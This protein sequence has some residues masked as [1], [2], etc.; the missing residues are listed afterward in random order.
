MFAPS[1]FPTGP[2]ETHLMPSRRNRPALSFRPA[3]LRLEE[4]AVPSASIV[5]DI[6]TDRAGFRL[7][8]L[9]AVGNRVFFIT[10]ST[11]PLANVTLWQSDGTAAGTTPVRSGQTT[12]YDLTPFNGK[13]Y[14]FDNE[15]LWVT[16]GTAAGTTS[17]KGFTGL[18]PSVLGVLNGTLY[19]GADGGNTG[20]ELWKTDGTATGTA[21]VKDINPGTGYGVF[22]QKGVVANNLLYFMGTDG[23][24]GEELW[25]TDGTAAG[26]QMVKDL[27]PGSGGVAQLNA[28]VFKGALY[29]TFTTADPA[30]SVPPAIWTTDGTDAGTTQVVQLNV[31]NV[32]AP[33]L[34]PTPNRLLIVVTDPQH[35]S[36]VYDSDGTQAGTSLVVKSVAAGQDYIVGLRDATA[37]GGGLFYVADDGA[38][39]EQVYVYRNPGVGLGP[40]QSGPLTALPPNN[41]V[42]LTAVTDGPN[43]HLY[44]VSSRGAPSVASPADFSTFN[45]ARLFETNG[46]NAGTPVRFFHS[47]RGG[48]SLTDSLSGLL[49]VVAA[50]GQAYF[51]A[52]DPVH[53]VELWKETP[54][55]PKAQLLAVGAGTIT[56]VNAYDAATGSLKYH[57][58]AYPGFSG[59]VRV[60]VGDVTGDGVDD[61]VTAPGPGGGPHVKV[62]DG[63]TG[64]VARQ[65]YAYD[66]RFTAG[67]FVAVGDVNQDGFA[68]IITGAGAGGGPHVR[69]FSG[70]DGSLLT[71][72]YAYDPRFAGGV[73][74]ASG[75][76]AGSPDVITG[77]G[78]GAGPHVK[79]FDGLTGALVTQFYGQAPTFTGGVTVA[80]ADTNADGNADIVVGAGPGNPAGPVVNV[81]SGLELS[82]LR[83]SSPYP[84]FGGG[85]TVAALDFAGDGHAAVVTGPGPGGGP[86]VR[87][88]G[89]DGIP[90]DLTKFFAFNPAFLGGVFVG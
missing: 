89:G 14:F 81:Y 3:L 34:V 73:T 2:R 46:Q 27:N 49:Q 52:Y 38:N 63:A 82:L 48:V 16:D 9:T 1:Y 17:L 28:A 90:P 13:L 33:N 79:V 37:F 77:A 71:Q 25:R 40:V 21:F 60:A 11:A 31:P 57:F 75:D 58:V 23:V 59:G 67:V 80:A 19:F 7:A 78:P 36:H 64:Q 66:P 29:F 4:R 51:P 12:P 18:A 65:F 32:Y 68:D 74:V 72:F 55:P 62:Y 35:G 22:A 86:D 85:L 45:E 42:R 56:Q 20:V 69:V 83:T 47:A 26:T 84:G 54:P 44:Y 30:H 87:A 5:K 24:H 8:E 61:I 6:N 76:V 70:K 88:T 10:Y 43:A 53:G 41:D 15:S 39:G 50:G